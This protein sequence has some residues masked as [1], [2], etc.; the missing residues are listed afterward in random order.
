MDRDQA[1]ALL[2][3]RARLR[4]ARDFAAADRARD[5]LRDGGWEVVDGPQGSE[6][7]GLTPTHEAGLITVDWGWPEDAKRWRESIGKY[8]AGDFVQTVVEPR[9]DVGWAGVVNQ[10]IEDARA[11]VLILFDASIEV[12]G[13]VVAPLSAALR[14]PTVAIA[15]PYGVRGKGGLKEFESHPGPEVDAIEGYCMAFRKAD[16]LSVGGFDPKFRFYRIADIEFSFR[17]RAQG[18]RRAVVVPLPVVKHEHRLWEA[19]TPDERERL[20]KRNFY[21]FLDRWRDREDLLTGSKG[22]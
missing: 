17:L 20:S 22:R 14:D 9:D 19:Q 3:E 7:R 16:A 21:R 8:S 1:E 18:N 5:Q 2:A 11:E 12:T 13:D 15:G 10:A 6:L 4:A